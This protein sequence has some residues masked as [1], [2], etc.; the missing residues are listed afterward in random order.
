V[1]NGTNLVGYAGKIH[2]VPQKIGP[3]DL[4]RIN[5]SEHPMIRSFATLQSAE[6]ALK[7]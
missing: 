6:L 4:D 2:A 3:V 7:V 5:L 1:I